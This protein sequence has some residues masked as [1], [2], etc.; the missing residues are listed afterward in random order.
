[1]KITKEEDY[2]VTFLVALAKHYNKGY[3]GLH[4][5]SKKYSLPEM[6]LKQIAQKLKKTGYLK[7]KE[8]RGGGYK[9]AKPTKQISLDEILKVFNPQPFLTSCSDCHGQKTCGIYDKCQTRKNWEQVSDTIY[10]QLG[11]ISVEKLAEK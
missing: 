9:L 1:M 5:I 3:L 6:F 7:V 11:S 8:G 2:A 4:E 10:K